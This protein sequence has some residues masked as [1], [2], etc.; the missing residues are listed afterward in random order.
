VKV[1]KAVNMDSVMMSILVPQKWDNK[2]VEISQI[3]EPGDPGDPAYYRFPKYKDL[4]DIINIEGILGWE[5]ISV[6]LQ[7]LEILFKRPSVEE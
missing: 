1:H 3:L 4:I 7:G 2:V 5:L 6:D